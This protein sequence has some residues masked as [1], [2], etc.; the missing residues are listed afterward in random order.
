MSYR[1]AQSQLNEVTQELGKIQRDNAAH[2]DL[3]ARLAQVQQQKWAFGQIELALKRGTKTQEAGPL[4]QQIT[5]KLMYSI[6]NEASR[7]LEKLGWHMSVEYEEKTGFQVKDRATSVTRHYQE[8]SG[9]E[10]FA[11]AISVALAVSR[12]TNKSSYIRCLFIDEGFGALDGKHRKRIVND[13]I[14]MLI[15]RGMRDQVVVITHIEDMQEYFPHRI[16]LKRKDD[17]SVLVT[18]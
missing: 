17:Y 14:G 12:V 13:A 15:E 5:N 16:E 8:Y 11:V 6:S 4:M 7:T 2:R 10:Q 3:R 18:E 9:G 1:L